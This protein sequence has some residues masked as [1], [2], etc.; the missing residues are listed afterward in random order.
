[1]ITTVIIEERQK[2]DDLAVEAVL[3]QE[4]RLILQRTN[5]FRERKKGSIFLD[6]DNHGKYRGSGYTCKD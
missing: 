3:I 2:V 5:Y 1:M 6:F 4:L